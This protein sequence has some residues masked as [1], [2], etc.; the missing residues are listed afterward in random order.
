MFVC[1]RRNS[2]AR[3]FFFFFKCFHA[4][5][6]SV[7]AWLRVTW[8]VSFL[9]TPLE[10]RSTSE[11][12]HRSLMNRSPNKIPCW[13]CRCEQRKKLFEGLWCVSSCWDET[14]PGCVLLVR[15]QLIPRSWGRGLIKPSNGVEDQKTETVSYKC[16][17]CCLK[18]RDNETNVKFI[19]GNTNALNASY[20]WNLFK[21]S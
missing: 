20:L 8:P 13:H 4:L 9:T 6:V 11:I 2:T 21:Q 16:N 10:C 14:T 1:V 3:Q 7:C 12:L 19:K 17:W 5:N 15:I 18:S